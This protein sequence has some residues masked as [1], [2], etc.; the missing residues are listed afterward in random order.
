MY[1]DNVFGLVIKLQLILDNAREHS[2]KTVMIIT[3]GF[4][5]S[6]TAIPQ[7]EDMRERNITIITF[8]SCSDRSL[9]LRKDKMKN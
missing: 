7:A 6:D 4:T 8:G 9:S 3:N 2:Q 5:T 1:F